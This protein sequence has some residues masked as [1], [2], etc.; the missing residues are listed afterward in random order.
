MV[1]HPIY[2]Q[3]NVYYEKG[4]K[5]HIAVWSPLHSQNGVQELLEALDI[6]SS[7]ELCVTFINMNM[8]PLEVVEKL[9]LLQRSGNLK[10]QVLKRYLYSYLNSIGIECRYNKSYPIPKGY[11]TGAR[12][13]DADSVDRQ[14]LLQ[15]LKELNARY[16]YDYTEYQMDSV[17]RRIKISMLRESTNDLQDFKE[18]V[19]SDP[20]LFEQVFLDF[21][22]NTTEFFRDPEVFSVIRK[23]L[24]PYLNSFAHLR[25]W[26]AGCSNGK[27][28][29]SLAMLLHEMGMMHKTRIYA[30][31]INPY[32][33]GEAKNGLYPIDSLYNDSRRYRLAGG[34]KNF[35]DYFDVT[36]KYMKIKPEYRK[37]ILF[38]QHSLVGSGILNEFQLILCRNVLIYFNPELQKKVLKNFYDSLDR[39]GFLVLGKSEGMLQ[40]HGYELFLKYMESE[41]IFKKSVKD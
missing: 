21:S 40:N 17:A 8:L 33:I 29:Y 41:K 32:I 16:G 2:M 19:L 7:S 20:N 39:S 14:Q 23:K 24:L 28:A 34:E 36:E 11:G 22:I 3:F 5:K 15:F 37:N 25:I 13:A 26:C 27:E 12:L 35:V 31:D 10:V 18:Q 30:T 9:Y 38:F 1:L 4:N 6:G